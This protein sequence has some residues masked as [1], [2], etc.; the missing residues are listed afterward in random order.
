MVQ[1][2]IQHCGEEPA[3]LMTGGA[4]W[5]MAPSMTRPFELLDNLIF[6][7][8]LEIAARRSGGA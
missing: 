1:H 7:G 6:D 4:G 5:K 8:L 2:V 3:C